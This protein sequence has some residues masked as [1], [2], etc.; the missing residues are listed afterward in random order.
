MVCDEKFKFVQNHTYQLLTKAKQLHP[1]ERTCVTAIHVGKLSSLESN[2][3]H[4]FG[5]DEILVVDCDISEQW[6]YA[7]I[8]EKVISNEEFPLVL[9]PATDWGKSSAAYIAGQLQAGLIADCIGIDY[10]N[11]QYVF[12]RAALNSSVIVNICCVNTNV[13]MCTVKKN[14]FVEREINSECLNKI[15]NYTYTI[16][17]QYNLP[18]ILLAQEIE[19]ANNTL[20]EQAK[21]VF[22]VGRGIKNLETFLLL[23]KVAKRYAAEI[24]G[25][26]AAVEAGYVSKAR[27]VGQSGISISPTLYISFGISGASQHLAGLLNVKRIISINIDFD[28]PIKFQSDIFIVEDCFTVLNELNALNA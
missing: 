14:V 9:F 16:E 20:L 2:L 1:Y 26:R 17:R 21:I 11:N 28:A 4:R 6:T 22:G 7:K 10:D 19:N 3:L 18:K 12:C 23:Q 5:A 25:T 15:R 8:L 27:Q 24:A 13:Q